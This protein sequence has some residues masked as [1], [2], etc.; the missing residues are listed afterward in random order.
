M[1]PENQDPKDLLL[2]SQEQLSFWGIE[3][4]TLGPGS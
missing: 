2:G 4:N 3:Y 1:E